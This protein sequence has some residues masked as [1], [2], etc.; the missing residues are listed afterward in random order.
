[1]KKTKY[2][3]EQISGILKEAEAGMQTV[4]VYREESLSV[5]LMS[6]A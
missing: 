1:M 4:R 2:S 5:V 6:I 3:E